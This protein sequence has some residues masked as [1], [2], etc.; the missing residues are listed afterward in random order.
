MSLGLLGGGIFGNSVGLFPPSRGGT[1]DSLEAVSAMLCYLHGAGGN[2]RL[3]ATEMHARV[4]IDA[5]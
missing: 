5:L 2:G 3:R 4:Y 1:Q